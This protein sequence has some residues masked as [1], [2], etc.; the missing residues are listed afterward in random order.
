MAMVPS[1]VPSANGRHYAA[2]TYL[3]PGDEPERARLDLQHKILMAHTPMM[4][5]SDLVLNPGDE[6]LDAGTGTGIW[7]TALAQILPPSVNLTGID[8]QSRLFPPALRN[9]TF[10]VCSTLD[11]PNEWKCKFIYVHQR[12]MVLAFSL[13][14]WELSLSGFFRALKPGGWLRLEEWDAC[15]VFEGHRQAGPYYEGFKQALA[16]LGEGRGIPRDNLLMVSGMIKDA[17]FDDVKITKSMSLLGADDAVSN[18]MTAWRGLKARFLQVGGLGL[19][20]ADEE[21]DTFMDNLE[22]ELRGS[23]TELMFVTW[24]ARKPL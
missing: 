4:L 23:F 15:R 16:V 21:F 10:L 24:T 22:E 19:G 17:G 8:L 7:L 14:A 18:V 6:I 12:L 11:L 1:K 20:V 5:P 13:D 9:T 2:D 3:L